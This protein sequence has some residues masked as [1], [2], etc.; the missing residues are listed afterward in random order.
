MTKKHAGCTSLQ[1]V[2]SFLIPPACAVHLPSDQDS[3]LSTC[4]S[5]GKL[6]LNFPTPE[7]VRALQKLQDGASICRKEEGD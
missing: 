6:L 3:N 4:R 2:H 1:G 5:S 7:E